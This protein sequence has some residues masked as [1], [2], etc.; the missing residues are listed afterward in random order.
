[1]KKL[2]ALLSIMLLVT[3]CTSVSRS[4][5]KVGKAQPSISGTQ[6]VLADNI[7]G[8]LPTLR[9]ENGKISGNAGCNDYF[10]E[11]RLTPDLGSFS[12][13]KIGATKMFC[14]NM[15]VEKNFLNM[16]SSANKYVVSGNSLELYK[17]GLLLM[18]LSKQ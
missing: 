13:S 11:L 18:K 8:K 12:A 1:M 17:D 9:I 7:K 4:A 16:L 2:I 3:A 6:W 14:K 5:S 10:G 15:S